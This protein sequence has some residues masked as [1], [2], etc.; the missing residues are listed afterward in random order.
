M[1]Y[2]RPSYNLTQNPSTWVERLA[3][4]GYATKGIVYGLIGMLALTAAFGLGGQT[5]DSNG[6]LQTISRQP[7]GQFLLILLTI[8]LLGYALWRFIECFQD[9]EHKGSDA[10]GILTRIGYAISGLIYAGLA[11]TS[12]KL[13]IGAGSGNSNSQQDWTAR[14]LAQPFGQWLIGTIGAI[15]IGMAFYMFYKAYKTK[16]QRELDLREL[17]SNQEK[18][19]INIC[20]FG[21]A[22]RA[23][24]FVIIGFFL[25]Q[26][27]RFSNANEVKGI[28]GALQ[29]VGQ[30]PFGKVLLSL[31]ALGL[32]A[33]GIYMAV[34]ARYKRLEVA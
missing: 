32:V 27:A 26:A 34:Q 23:I 3:R 5:T 33:Y 14:I 28:D 24:V 20:R 25:I 30:Q 16:F 4:W 6:A 19:I 15:I 29:T 21:I 13:V 10:K 2:N 7:F 22:A 9:P 17:D 8:G 12:A 1:S 11:F 18:V 31:V